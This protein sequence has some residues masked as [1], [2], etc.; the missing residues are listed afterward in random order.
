MVL[1]EPGVGVVLDVSRRQGAGEGSPCE[2]ERA[3]LLVAQVLDLQGQLDALRENFTE[4]TQSVVRL[5]QRLGEVRGRLAAQMRTSATNSAT[6]NQL[7]RQR[8]IAQDHYVELRR[9]L[10]QIDLY[11]ALTPAA[12]DGRI[13]VSPPT[14]PDPAARDAELAKA[15]ASKLGVDEAK[16]TAALDEIRAAREAERTKALGDRLAAAVKAGTLT[17]AEADAVTKA[18]EKGVIDVGPR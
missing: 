16:V 1:D 14:R 11:M 6:F 5:R 10:G 13:V 8:V 12:L 7:E 4:Q 15:L 9:K 2:G 3:R 18:A 17:Q